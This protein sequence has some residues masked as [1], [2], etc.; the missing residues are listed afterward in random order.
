M[1]ETDVKSDSENPY[2]IFDDIINDIHEKKLEEAE[3]RKIK[4]QILSFF[5]RMG[6]SQTGENL[7]EYCLRILGTIPFTIRLF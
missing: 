5:R 3:I 1:K 2:H 7:E 6:G 4:S